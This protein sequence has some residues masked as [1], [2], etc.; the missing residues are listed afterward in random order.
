V[1]SLLAKDLRCSF[2]NVFSGHKVLPTE[3]LVGT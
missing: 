2:K 3:R 1:E